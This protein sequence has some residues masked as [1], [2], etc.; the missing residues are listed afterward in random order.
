MKIIKELGTRVSGSGKRMFVLAQCECGKR[1]EAIK[2]KSIFGIEANAK[3]AR[4]A[5]MNM[6]VHGDGG[7]RI[8]CA[9]SLDKNLTIKP[10][11]KAAKRR[12]EIF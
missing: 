11:S 7:S 3:I 10:G 9:D 5:R 6:Y 4:I 2:S 8:Y 1:I 12:K